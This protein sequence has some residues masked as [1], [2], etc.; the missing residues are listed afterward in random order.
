MSNIPGALIAMSGGV[1]S[2]VAA[3]LMKQAG[4][5][6]MGATMRLY[7][8]EDLGQSGFHTCCSA[9]DVEDAA[10]VAFQLDIPFEV[11]NY[12][13][14]FRE[15]V[16]AKFIETYEAGGTPNPCI[17]C[18]RTMKFD[19]ML[20]FAREHGLDYVVTG[21]YARIEQ[22][23]ATGRW[24]L[25]KALYTDKDQSYVLYVLTQDQLAHTKFPLGGMDKPSIRKIAEEQGFCNARKHDSQDICFVP[26][27]DYVGFMERYTG[28]YYPDGDFLDVNGN[29]VGRHHGAV[30]YTNG[31]RKG[32]GV[33]MAHPVYVT[34]VDAANN[35]VHLGEAEDLTATALT[36]DD[37]IWSAPADRME[38]ELT[39][40]G[41]RVGAKY[42]Y[43][44]KDQAATLTR[45]ADGQ[46]L[47][48]FD[49]PQRAI[50]PGQAVV[51]YRGDVV[52]GGGTVTGA[53]K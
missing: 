51:I 11:V 32:L 26:D 1:D 31:Q 3:Y 30:R 24:L 45:G 10:E 6:C 41:I 22:D 17:D 12:T 19:K 49:E 40:G 28:K 9:K 36:A 50:A 53:I 34:G 13:E 52:L 27:G 38:A 2:T 35:I 29:V 20:D 15:K 21:H 18:N 43:R 48:T 5:R 47:L 33:A 23:P 25:K 4:Y 7:Q 46:M 42:R 14:E 44:Q 37:W 16:I 8:N 39:S